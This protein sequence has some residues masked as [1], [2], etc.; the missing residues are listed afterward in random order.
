MRPGPGE[1]PAQPRMSLPS[2]DLCSFMKP[3]LDVVCPEQ[4][5]PPF[6]NPGQRLT[7]FSP[8][9]RCFGALE[10]WPSDLPLEPI[11]RLWELPATGT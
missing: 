5:R 7:L 3:G 6:Q 9:V 1:G 2:L 11:A 8:S 10:A 4:N